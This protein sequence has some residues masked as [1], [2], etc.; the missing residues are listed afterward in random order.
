MGWDLR[1]WLFRWGAGVRVESPQA[2]QEQHLQQSRGVVEL[3]G[4]SHSD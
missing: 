1:A 4:A 2:L 3:Y